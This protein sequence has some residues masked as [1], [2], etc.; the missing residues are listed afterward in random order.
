MELPAPTVRATAL[1][2]TCESSGTLGLLRHRISARRGDRRA[3]NRRQCL[4][5]QIW[6]GLVCSH[7]LFYSID[8]FCEPPLEGEWRH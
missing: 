7:A 3:D 4:S 2:P 6:N 5:G 8:T 1:D